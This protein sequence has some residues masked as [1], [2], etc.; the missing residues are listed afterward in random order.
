[1]ANMLETLYD[2]HKA[3]IVAVL[4]GEIKSK[5]SKDVVLYWLFELDGYEDAFVKVLGTSWQSVRDTYA[6]GR[7]DAD[8]AMHDKL[9]DIEQAMVDEALMQAGYDP[10]DFK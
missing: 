2:L 8:C 10:G 4:V 5:E 7:T 9:T 1:M 3:E 6:G